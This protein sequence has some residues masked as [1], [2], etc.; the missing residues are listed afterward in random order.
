MKKVF[1]MIAVAVSLSASA[2][3]QKP[4][5]KAPANKPVTDTTKAEPGFYL[6]GRLDDFKLLYTI[7][8]SPGD[9]TPNQVKGVA[10]WINKGI[11]PLVADTT[12]K[13]P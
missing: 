3:T 5:T 12:R 10:E 11:Q 2:Q 4:V 13:K 1:L 6:L 9:V 8:V 7:L